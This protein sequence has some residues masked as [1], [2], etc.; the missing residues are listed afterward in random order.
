MQLFLEALC[1]ILLHM[2]EYLF[3]CFCVYCP[4]CNAI[5][6]VHS[7]SLSP[8]S[9]PSGK[10][11][12]PS[13]PQDGEGISSSSSSSFSSCLCLILRPTT[14]GGNGGRLIYGG[15][16]GG[17]GGGR[18]FGAHGGG[19]SAFR[20]WTVLKKKLLSEIYLVLFE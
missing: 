20:S 18:T 12:S 15:L 6:T 5:I 13:L 8:L 17:E 1:W 11:S 19:G 7:L 14:K 10:P 2:G 9:L 3:A 4:C 16:S